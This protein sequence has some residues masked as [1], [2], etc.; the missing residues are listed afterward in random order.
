MKN[1]KT[2]DGGTSMSRFKVNDRSAT[3]RGDLAHNDT[4]PWSGPTPHTH[5]KPTKHSGYSGMGNPRAKAS[6]RTE[7][8][9]PVTHFKKNEKSMPGV[10]VTP[11]KWHKKN[12]YDMTSPS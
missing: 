4:R 11:V 5:S 2:F 6:D 3:G 12:K 7:Q 9:T 1:P 10:P 8:L